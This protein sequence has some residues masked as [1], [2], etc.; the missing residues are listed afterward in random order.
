MG[1]RGLRRAEVQFGK[2]VGEE[3]A[4]A[5]AKRL[6]NSLPISAVIGRWGT[7][8]FVAM[9]TAKKSE[10]L[11]S[12]KWITEHLSGTYACLN[13]GKTVRPAVQL[14]VGVVDTSAHETPERI[15]ERVGAFLV[16]SS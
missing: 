9:L 5:F 6:R 10:A 15:L 12:A 16:G 4:G 13:A 11:T 3:L 7:E 2:E 8:E 14:T 1:A